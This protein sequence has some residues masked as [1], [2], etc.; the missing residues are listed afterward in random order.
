[1]HSEDNSQNPQESLKRSWLI[2]MRT[3]GPILKPAFEENPQVR[4]PLIAALNHISR[5][6]TDRGL[7]I[8]GSIKDRCI[9]DED[10]AAWTFFVGL[11]YEMA[12]DEEKMKQWYIKSGRYGHSFY[13]PY[14]KTAKSEHKAANFL[15]AEVYYKKAIGCLEKMKK[16]PMDEIVLTS[17][18]TNLVSCL[19]MMHRY[20]EAETVWNYANTR[21]VQPAAFATAAI[22]YAAM[23]DKE[24]ADY[25]LS[26]LHKQMPEMSV[27]QVTDMIFAG[28]HPHFSD[29]D[30]PSETVEFFWNWFR[31]NIR[32][33]TDSVKLC[34]IIK[35]IFPF[36]E[37]EPYTKIDIQNGKLVLTFRDFYSK[38]L[39][40]GFSAL[41]AGCPE[42]IAASRTFCII[43]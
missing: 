22:M 40:S 19:T 17:A 2:H 37:R 34:D 35:E 3:F 36:M 7:E 11:C 31:E 21:Q 4:V 39:N 38:G 32:N 6:E 9:Y 41:I 15:P 43:H 13:L 14:L 28:E 33:D 30:V 25:F 8:L 18:Y 24:K 16:G 29:V 23:G 10:K 42:D 27:Q 20:D 12:G 5:K 1:M 26:E